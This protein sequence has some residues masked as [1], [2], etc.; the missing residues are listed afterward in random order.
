VQRA[1]TALTE[2]KA[3]LPSSKLEENKEKIKEEMQA[4]FPKINIVKKNPKALELLDTLN[5][6]EWEQF[7][8]AE[9]DEKILEIEGFE[10]YLIIHV[11]NNGKEKLRVYNFKHEK[12]HELNLEEVDFSIEKETPQR[13]SSPFYLFG[14]K[15][16]H[17]PNRVFSYNMGLRSLELKHSESYPN[18]IPS[19]Y[20]SERFDY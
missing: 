13:F 16:P 11:S 7:Y 1:E 18:F 2:A 15:T 19:D 4:A 5:D 14:L 6:Y 9:K 20:T 12:Y 3:Q 10:H 17:L 8:I